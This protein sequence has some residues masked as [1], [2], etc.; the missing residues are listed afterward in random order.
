MISAGDI[1]HG[2]GTG[3]ESIYGQFF[4]DENWI[5]KHDKP[6][7]LSMANAGDENTCSSQFFITTR[8]APWC[9]E[10]HVVFG[11]VLEGEDIV[12]EI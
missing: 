4:D 8:V 1:T 7:L 2:D 5:H 3:G 12:E 6:Y 10:M 11:H 9:D